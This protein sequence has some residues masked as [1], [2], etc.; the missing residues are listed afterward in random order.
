MAF[1]RRQP[2]TRP[3]FCAPSTPLTTWP[4]WL[5]ACTSCG[6]PATSRFAP[7]RAR[8]ASV[9]SRNRRSQVFGSRSP[10]QPTSPTPSCSSV[11]A[12]LVLPS[13]GGLDGFFDRTLRG[14]VLRASS[15][16]TG[17]QRRRQDRRRRQPAPG[18]D[19]WHLRDRS[20]PPC[21]AAAACI[22]CSCVFSMLARWE[23]DFF[24]HIPPLAPPPFIASIRCR[25]ARQ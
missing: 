14:A 7:S 24:P 3:P 21:A 5:R 16:A 22:L 13:P 19:R 9:L 4:S 1:S 15:A 17:W 6:P 2:P 10:L 25:T 18:H 8:L 11:F 12:D 20:V 23:P